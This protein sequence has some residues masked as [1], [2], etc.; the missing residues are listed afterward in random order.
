MSR[1][2]FLLLTLMVFSAT[3]FGQSYEGFYR[4]QFISLEKGVNPIAEFE[5]QPSGAVT[6]QIVVG[7][8][9]TIIKGQINYDGNLEAKSANP[10]KM[11]YTL[12]ADMK[13]SD[14]KITLSS[15]SEE[16]AFGRQSGSQSVMQGSYSRIEKNAATENSLT[17]IDKKS[18]LVIEQPKPLFEKEFS[19]ETAKV[20]VEK[21]AFANVYHLQM[22]GGTDETERGFYFSL[23]RLQNSPQKIWKI[24]NIRALNYVEK[25]EKFTKINRFRIN[26]EMWRKNR[27][28]ASGQ[29]ELVSEDR[30]RII[31]KIT[32]LKIKNE[33]NDDMVTI[34]GIV[35]AEISK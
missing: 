3:A 29:I 31:F 14:R 22:M 11:F 30:Q 2:V 7:E 19:T 24:E 26:N 25:T 35:V 10:S 33:A 5:I 16:N 15:R 20:I 28:I 8:S 21:D 17:S 6:G 32:N 13:R 18:E 27:D 23:S 4:A 34:N 12:K 1:I 9:A